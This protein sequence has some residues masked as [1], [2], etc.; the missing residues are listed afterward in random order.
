[1]MTESLPVPSNNS[2]EEKV[3][4]SK[5]DDL[6]DSLNLFDV[7]N[8]DQ[9]DLDKEFE[10]TVT[11]P[12]ETTENILKISR[13]VNIAVLK[14]SGFEEVQT[15]DKNV[16]LFRIKKEPL[17]SAG[18]I[19]VFDS[20]LSSHADESQLAGKRDWNEYKIIA[21]ADW[22]AFY[23]Y[24]LREKATDDKHLRTVYRNFQDILLNIGEI[25]CDNK[26]SLDKLFG[27]MNLQKN[28]DLGGM[29]IR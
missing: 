4:K 5:F 11:L 23:K 18:V 10:Y 1:M 7:D 26:G 21:R 29:N 16:I 14:L 13:V 28:N 20:L 17:C 3:S 2:A 6:R 19:K 24:C 9:L 27:S 12:K 22:G 8:S 15:D 25:V